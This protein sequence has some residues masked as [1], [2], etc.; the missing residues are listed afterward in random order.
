MY[1]S[2]IF[3]VAN[4]H[5]FVKNSWK[6]EYFVVNSFFLKKKSPK[7]FFSLN[8]QDSHNCL[9]FERVLNFFYLSNITELEG[10]RVENYIRMPKKT[11]IHKHALPNF[12]I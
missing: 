1:A 11:I 9:Q 3:W 6:K 12:A 4:F 2:V 7:R 8:K 5:H 10:G